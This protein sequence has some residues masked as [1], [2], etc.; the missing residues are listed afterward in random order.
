MPVR[1]GASGGLIISHDARVAIGELVHG[2]HASFAR[3]MRCGGITRRR[4]REVLVELVDLAWIHHQYETWE[5]M[6]AGKRA[7][8]WYQEHGVGGPD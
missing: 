2:G 8:D 6:P 7:A 4:A 5:V 3:A 1:A